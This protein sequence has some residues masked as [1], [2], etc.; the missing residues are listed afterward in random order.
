MRNQLDV[1]IRIGGGLGKVCAVR[2]QTCRL[3]EGASLS[4]LL[5]LLSQEVG[6]VIFQPSVLVA[7]NGTLVQM[8]DRGNRLLQGGDV[9]SVIPAI[10]GG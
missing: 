3:P 10:A 9:V 5:T 1:T 8:N 6:E 4:D 2:S 7:V